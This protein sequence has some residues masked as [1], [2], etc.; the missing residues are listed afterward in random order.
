MK[1]AKNSEKK[2]KTFRKN[3]FFFLS[4]LCEVF[5]SFFVQKEDISIPMIILEGEGGET[6]QIIL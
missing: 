3:D 6:L 1:K 2:K 4:F 5:L